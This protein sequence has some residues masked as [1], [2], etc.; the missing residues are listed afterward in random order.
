MNNKFENFV[1]NER[2]FIVLLLSITLLGFVLRI[3]GL[4]VQPLSV[5][6]VVVAVSASKYTSTGHLG[7]TMWNH[8]VLRNLTVYLTMLISGGG[9]W[10]LKSASLL[11]GALSVPLLGILARRIFNSAEIACMAAFFL[12]IDSLHIDFSRQAVHE[13]YMM[14]FSLAAIYFALL[15]KDNSKPYPL[16][17]SGLFFGLGLASKWYVGFAVIV[18]F[19]LLVYDATASARSAKGSIKDKVPELIFI[20]SALA[21]I[22]LTVYLLTYIPWFQRGYGLSEWLYLQKTMFLETVTHAGYNPL[23]WE[24]DHNAYLW[25]VK[26]V[27][28]ADFVKTEGKPVVLLAISNPF[29]WL[30]TIPSMIY[31]GFVGV[32]KRSAPYHYLSGMFWLPYLP[33]MFTGRPIWTHTA[34][35]VIP[36]AFMAIASFLWEGAKGLKHGKFYLTIYLVVTLLGGIPLYLL[37]IGMGLEIDALV[38]IIMLYKPNYGY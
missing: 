34:F 35:A 33:L 21:V 27:A 1:L 16:I 7:P 24:L 29:V 26:P 30:L 6:D 10:G 19:I 2:S 13:V 20:F 8:P 36:F 37:A 25:F 18:T 15:Y 28:F 38:P 9:V 11:M 22:P 14:F 12:A 32:R 17:I 4:S 3:W 23:S 5:D 31:L